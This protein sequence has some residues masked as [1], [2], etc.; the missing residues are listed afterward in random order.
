[1][2]VARAQGEGGRNCCVMAT[3]YQFETLETF[4]KQMLVMITPPIL[5]SHGAIQWQDRLKW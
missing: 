3:E 5:V 2:V 1:M 4:F